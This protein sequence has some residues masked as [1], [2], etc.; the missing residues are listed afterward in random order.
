MK[1]TLEG[2]IALA[3]IPVVITVILNLNICAHC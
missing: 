2:L 1:Q 3:A